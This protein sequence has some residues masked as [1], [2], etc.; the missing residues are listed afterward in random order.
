VYQDWGRWAVIR[1][2]GQVRAPGM[3]PPRLPPGQA[4]TTVEFMDLRFDYSFRG[5][6]SP[7]EPP[8]LSGWVY[9]VDN[10]DDGGEAMDGREQK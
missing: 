2:V 4:W 9:I 1:D 7:P 8:P 6:G 3:E 10:R 5:S